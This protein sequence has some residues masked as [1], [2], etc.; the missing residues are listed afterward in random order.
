MH[1]LPSLI[2]CAL[3]LAHGLR[4]NS[5]S[6]SGGAAAVLVGLLT[7]TH[8]SLAPTLI[9]LGFYLVSSRL[10]KLGAR[11]KSELEEHAIEGGRRNAVQ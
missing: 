2:L 8:P 5:L 1:I 9:L 7:F 10:T 11:R 6:P 3:L 4:R